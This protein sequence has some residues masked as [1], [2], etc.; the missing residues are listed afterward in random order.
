[1]TGA[2]VTERKGLEDQL[3]QAQKLEAI[4]QLAAGIAHEI[5]TPTQ[6]TGDNLR[7]LKDSWESIAGF[8]NFCQSRAE[9]GKG[10]LSGEVLH[11]FET[12][13]EK[14]DFPYLL[15]EVPNAI[16]QSLEGLQRVAEIVRG[17]KEFSHPGSKE[18]VAVNLNRAIETT[19]TVSRNEWKYCADLVTAFDENLPLVPCLVGGFNQVMLNLIVNASHAIAAVMAAMD[20]R[21]NH[22]HYPAA[23]RMGR[24]PG[25]RHGHWYSEGIHSRVFEPFFT[26]KEVGKGTGQ[27]LALAHA[28]IVGQHQGQIWFDSEVGKG[29]TFHIRLPLNTDSAVT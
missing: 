20:P 3:R 7:F 21:D 6:Y 10:P 15:E 18:K 28:V 1:M 8:L 12:I 23:R 16:N 14:C 19:I 13:H 4:G 17:M 27:G 9:A 25:G 2:D 22:H 11:D 5:N 24:D 26:T 29:S